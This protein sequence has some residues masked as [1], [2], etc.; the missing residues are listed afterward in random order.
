VE[1]QASI[2]Q[3]PENLRRVDA[4][5][6][7]FADGVP[8]Q[9]DLNQMRTHWAVKQR[10]GVRA[11]HQAENW[12]DRADKSPSLNAF[13]ARYPTEWAETLRAYVQLSLGCPPTARELKRV[14]HHLDKC[15]A[16]RRACVRTFT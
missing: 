14:R 3:P 7:R 6:R 5:F 2:F 13:R 8:T 15:R 10:A 4:L 16:F 12:K 9:F 1:I 11:G